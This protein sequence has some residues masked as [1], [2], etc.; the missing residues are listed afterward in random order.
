MRSASKFWLRDTSA[1]NISVYKLLNAKLD[2]DNNPIRYATGVI[3]YNKDN[4]QRKS[5]PDVLIKYLEGRAEKIL[6]KL[7]G[8]FYRPTPQAIE[9]FKMLLRQERKEYKVLLLGNKEGQKKLNTIYASLENRLQQEQMRN[10]PKYAITLRELIAQ[11]KKT[12]S[13]EEHNEI[14]AANTKGA[15]KAL[16]APHD[17]LFDRLNLAFHALQ[18]K[19]QYHYDIPLLV[20]SSDKPPY[21]YTEA[22]IK[23]DLKEAYKL[24][25]E[26]QFPF[27]KSL[28]PV[29]KPDDEGMIVIKINEKGKKVF[30]PKNL[31][32]QRGLLVKLFQLGMPKLK[33]Y[34]QLNRGQINKN[35]MDEDSINASIDSIINQMDV[36]GGLGRETELMNRIFAQEDEKKQQAFFLR[37]VN[38]GHTTLVD[39]ILHKKALK[40]SSSILQKAILLAD[41]NNHTDLKQLL[42][43]NQEITTFKAKC[44]GFKPSYEGIA[45]LERNIITINE[46][47]VQF[48][49][50]SP[51]YDL[52]TLD[53][54]IKQKENE[55]FLNS[56]S[57]NEKNITQLPDFI[58]LLNS[59]PEY[60]KAYAEIL[61]S[62]QEVKLDQLI[63]ANKRHD[64]DKESVVNAL[65]LIA[66]K[67][68][69]V[70]NNYLLLKEIGDHEAANQYLAHQGEDS[71]LSK[72]VEQECKR[73]VAEIERQSMGA[74]DEFT[75]DFCE[76][77]RYAIDVNKENYVGL[78]LVLQKIVPVHAAV[79]SNEVKDVQIQIERL[80]HNAES[81][82]GIGN[83]KKADNIRAAV[84]KVSL[85]DRATLFS[86]ADKP[87]CKED[88]IALA[89]NRMAFGKPV[90]DSEHNV[91]ESNAA[92]S[93]ANV[94]ASFKK[95]L[96][97]QKIDISVDKEGN[98]DSLKK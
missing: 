88:R 86:N 24:I 55:V 38:L 78:K 8:N 52:S 46:I 98:I 34:S 65:T 5:T 31:D 45:S 48:A 69:E 76:A 6:A 1:F 83:Q 35:T 49:Q 22:L 96:D 43:K 16:Y 28:F 58:K 82:F 25:R 19:K 80:E 56:A 51:H 36:V 23:A 15:T 50:L 33:N 53:P 72:E 14:L 7:N 4:I 18:I 37:A 42:Q 89:S 29:Y 67:G 17:T 27:D 68:W 71:V 10:H 26:G 62:N 13:A 84:S 92:K 60:K 11:Q 59:Y 30:E 21:H 39:E 91:V 74:S 77:V 90:V 20:M 61:K 70:A 40:L 64:H 54:Q 9:D 66:A 57:I 44:E 2:Q 3:A 63:E 47:K 97:E 85:L 95:R 32:Y 79:T 73:L 41:N 94:K 81:M 75:H 87:S 12:N 93:F